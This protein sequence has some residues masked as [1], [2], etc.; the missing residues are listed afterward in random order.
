MKNLPERVQV[1]PTENYF[2]FRFTHNGAVTT[3]T[4]VLPPPTAT[5][6]R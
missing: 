1:Y 4:S 6:A 2:Y 5:T 3:A